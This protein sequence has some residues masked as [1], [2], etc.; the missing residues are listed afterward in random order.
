MHT[1][2][3]LELRHASLI[4]KLF[5]S[6]AVTFFAKELPEQTAEDA[7]RLHWASGA[8]MA[9]QFVGMAGDTDA[10]K[11]AQAARDLL[12]FDPAEMTQVTIDKASQSCCKSCIKLRYNM[13]M[14]S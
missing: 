3:T 7:W 14:Y 10:Q 9:E 8:R 1:F 5:W 13:K 6:C 2:D 11:L 12:R 4:N